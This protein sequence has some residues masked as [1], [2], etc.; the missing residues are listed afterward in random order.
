MSGEKNTHNIAFLI[1]RSDAFSTPKCFLT[2]PSLFYLK[3]C[4]SATE[5]NG[6][7]GNK[8]FNDKWRCRFQQ[9]FILNN[10]L[11][12]QIKRDLNNVCGYSKLYVGG[13]E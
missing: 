5:A 1:S 9:N 12:A 11:L 3:T 10:H 4:T 7:G 13:G 2:P 8:V 6:T